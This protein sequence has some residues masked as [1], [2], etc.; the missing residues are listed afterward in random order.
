M[1]FSVALLYCRHVE[2]LSLSC[3]ALGG[4]AGSGGKC[5]CRQVTPTS[6]RFALVAHAVFQRIQGL[7]RG[8]RNHLH[9]LP[10]VTPVKS[11]SAFSAAS[12]NQLSSNAS[13]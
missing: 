3:P 10:I 7:F 1:S 5:R 8:F 12:Y 9:P 2:P 13:R 6:R 11:I 4:D